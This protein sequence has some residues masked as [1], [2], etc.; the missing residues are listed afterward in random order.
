MKEFANYLKMVANVTLLSINADIIKFQEFLHQ[1]KPLCLLIH[2]VL[3]T[4][5]FN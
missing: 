2:L 4:S 3:N 5:Q 1:S